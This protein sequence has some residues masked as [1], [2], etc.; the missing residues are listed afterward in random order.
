[1]R[2]LHDRSRCG[3]HGQCVIAAPE[4]F[5][6]AEDSELAYDPQPDEAL[7]PAAEAAADVCPEG[8]IT[9]LDDE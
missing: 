2:V 9:V 5:R 1:M 8:A 4:I 6:F 7:R 3:L